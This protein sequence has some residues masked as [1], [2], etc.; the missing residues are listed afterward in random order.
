MQSSI[1]KHI[2]H[3]N[4]YLVLDGISANKKAFISE[5]FVEALEH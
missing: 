3:Q 1:M 2:N 4:T 5:G